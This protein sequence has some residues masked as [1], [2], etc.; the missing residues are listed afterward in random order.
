MKKCK[1]FALCTK[2]FI[3]L[4]QNMWAR[5]LGC[6]SCLSYTYSSIE[7]FCLICSLHKMIKLYSSFC[8]KIWARKM[9]NEK[10]QKICS[11]Y[12]I[13]TLYLSFCIEIEARTPRR[14]SCLSYTYSNIEKLWL[15]CPVLS[16]A[17]WSVETAG[18]HRPPRSI[19]IWIFF[20]IISAKF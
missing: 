7:I 14:A 16:P 8:I 17:H 2:W 20:Y 19:L 18:N 9:K 15:I 1:K 13:F 4:H 6:A 12:Q 10:V 5:T 11:E 3:C